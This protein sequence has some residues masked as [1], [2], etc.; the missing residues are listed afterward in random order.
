MAWH[1][2]EP[3][4]PNLD[5]SKI[6]PTYSFAVSQ[7]FCIFASSAKKNTPKS[8]NFGFSGTKTEHKKEKSTENQSV[9]P[10]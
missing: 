7:K 3:T 6:N 4:R 10:L 9:R 2:G 5:A 8:K 1:E